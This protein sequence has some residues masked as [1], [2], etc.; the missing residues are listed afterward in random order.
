M[1]VIQAHQNHNQNNHQ[2][3]HHHHHYVAKLGRGGT[4]RLLSARHGTDGS[5]RDLADAAGPHF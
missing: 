5:N 4:G 1:I 2:H 3:R